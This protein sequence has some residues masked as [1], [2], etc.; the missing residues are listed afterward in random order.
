MSGGNSDGRPS[1]SR[2]VTISRER[3]HFRDY[4][5]ASKLYITVHPSFLLRVPD[6]ASKKREFRAFLQ[7]LKRIGED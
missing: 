4:P 1:L 2:T 7:D 3:G 5:P 6:E